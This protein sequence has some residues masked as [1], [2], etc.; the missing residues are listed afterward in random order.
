[1]LFF[2]RTL[3]SLAENLAL[4]E[5]LLLDICGSSDLACLQRKVS[6]NAQQRKRSHLLQHGTLLYDF[7]AERVGNYLTMPP[8]QP[9]YREHRS[10][11]K[12]LTNISADAEQLTSCL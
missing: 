5:A 12:F 4:D 8:R 10:H 2:D 11:S 9:D 1:M 7:D 6:G 3:P